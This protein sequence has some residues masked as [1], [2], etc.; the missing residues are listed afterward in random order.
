MRVLIVNTSEKTGGAAVA[1][2]RLC[3]ALINNGV[4]AKMLVMQKT[5]STLHV[6]GLNSP[7]LAK[8]YFVF[9]RFAIWLSNRFSMA[10]LFKVSIANTGF[11]ITRTDEFRQADIIHLHWTCQGFLS[12]KSIARILGSGKPVVWTMH[13]M[14]PMTSI[15]HHAYHCQ[16]YERQC[17][18]CH[19]LRRPSPSDLS[20]ATFRRKQKAYSSG[21]VH[22]VAVSSWLAGKAAA[23]SLIGRF[24][25]SVIP[26]SISLN[27]FSHVNRTDARSLL[28]IDATYVVAFGAYR[29]DDPIKGLH[30]LLSALQ[31]LVDTRGIPADSIRLLL[32][33]GVKDS[34]ILSRIPVPYTHFGY[35]TDE[36]QLS[37]IYSA[38]NALVSSSLYE[39]FGQTLIE[40]MCCGCLPV[41]FG[42]SGQQDIIRHLSNGY[43][44]QPQSAESLAE[45]LLWAFRT[46]V[47]AKTLRSDVA[48]RYSESVVA[49]KHIDLYNRLLHQQHHD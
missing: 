14:W 10:N 16:A 22:F 5:S 40:A 21:N 46:D 36:A 29:I 49:F 28:S 33:G 1:A 35:V 43:L 19:F 9:E 13:D 38:S 15:C 42:G 24:P 20:A 25:V 18:N 6:S 44:A 41:A 3:E 34:S 2:S 30:H 37:L 4:K 48:K 26:N 11:D 31:L 27:D 23:S 17:S 12:L 32:F 39:T 45:G 8:F 47:P 7:L